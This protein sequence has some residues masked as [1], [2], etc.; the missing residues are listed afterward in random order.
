MYYLNLGSDSF[1]SIGIP[2]GVSRSEFE[3]STPSTKINKWKDAVAE[4]F[5]RSKDEV[6][7]SETTVDAT[8]AEPAVDAMRAQK[9]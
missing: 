3:A 6:D 4:Y 1:E 8:F 9:E 5:P 7:T 2:P